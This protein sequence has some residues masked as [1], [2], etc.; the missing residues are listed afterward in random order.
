MLGG[1][2]NIKM[3]K[4]YL[5]S[6][7]I[8]GGFLPGFQIKLPRGLTCI[9]GP[10]GS[11]KSTLAEALRYGVGGMSNASKPRADL[12]HANLGSSVI[13]IKTTSDGDNA[14]YTIKRVYRQP[15]SL[16]N[17]DGTVIETVDLDRGTFLPLDGY[18]SSEIEA[19]AQ[20][21][22]GEKRRA[23]L[24]ELRGE[25]LRHIQMQIADLRRALEANADRVRSTQRSIGDLTEHIE[26][27]GDARA[28]LASLSVQADDTSA[29]LRRASKQQQFN[30]RETQELAGIV[31]GLAQ[32]RLSLKQMVLQHDQELSKT[33]GVPESSNLNLLQTTEQAIRKI[34]KNVDAHFSD[35]ETELQH[36][37]EIIQNA[38]A[39]LEAFHNVQQAEHVRLREQ[40]MAA[41]QAIQL[42]A[43]AEQAVATLE[44][45]EAQRTKLESEIYS[46]REARK[47]FKGQ[48]LNERS[49][50][51][52]LRDEV[53]TQLQQEAVSNVRIRVQR[54]ADSLSYQ[55][56]L[57]DG[58][59]GAGVRNHEDI[60]NSL[61][62]LP[63]EQLAQIIQDNDATELEVLLSLGMERS[64][65]IVEAFQKNLDPMVLEIVPIEDRVC[66]ELNVA[67]GDEPN[68]K[69]ASELSRGQKC[70]ALLPLLM[71]RRDTPLVIDQPEDNLDNHFIYETVVETIRR[72]KTRRQMI[73]ITHNANIPV[74]AEAELVIVMNSDGKIG[75]IEKAGSLDECQ[76]EIVDLLEG[77]RHAFELRRQRYART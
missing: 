10:R 61:M 69:D 36:L 74:L 27:H 20:E 58:L 63:P 60:L 14:S 34:T 37:S 32:Y 30:E 16:V 11:G 51:S 25:E 31:D 6:I 73:F 2:K 64:R 18:S 1:G 8:V 72:L 35:V 9:I 52:D 7:E 26:E 13:S 62:H 45:L 21:S 12:I 66:I 70:T 71:A 39:Q 44:A 46:L 17:M 43:S 42:R 4:W 65:K 56:M 57:T 38:Q 77:G 15:A 76:D 24:D 28:R 67:K 75:Y 53:A 29:E 33:L 49:H 68:L 47:I 3:A 22:L 40:N 50:V 54:N 23:L 55:Q 59:R 19:I 48:Y 41:S 5:D